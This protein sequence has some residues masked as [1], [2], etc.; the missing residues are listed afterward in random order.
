MPVIVKD[1]PTTSRYEVL[2]DEEV[3]GFEQYEISVDRI[4][5]LHT[6]IDAAYAG[7]GLAA[8]LV[9]EAVDDVRR[10]G[11]F[12]LPFC[13]YVPKSIAD[14]PEEYLDLAPE[15]ERASFGL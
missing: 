9:I 6:E 14:H 15:G 8:T 10:R 13:P 1:N 7:K 12:V 5:F 11:L 4:S 2:D 3:A